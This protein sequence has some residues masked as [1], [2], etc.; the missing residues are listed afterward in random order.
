MIAASPPT[1][2]VVDGVR[3]LAPNDIKVIIIG[4]GVGG[5]QAALELWRKGCE[6]T[7]LEKA[8]NL[9]PLGKSIPYARCDIWEFIRYTRRLLYHYALGLDHPEGLSQHAR[10]LPSMHL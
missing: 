4:A 7:V 2:T 6:V 9:S 5:L 10:R 8:D 1:E 3:R